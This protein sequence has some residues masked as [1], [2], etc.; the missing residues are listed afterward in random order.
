MDSDDA[1]S[2]Q[3]TL[4]NSICC[5]FRKI[6]RPLKTL[7]TMN[8]SSSLYTT[9]MD[10]IIVQL[11]I[12][13]IHDVDKDIFPTVVRHQFIDDMPSPSILYGVMLE[14]PSTEVIKQLLLQ[15]GLF[16]CCEN[17]IHVWNNDYQKYICQKKHRNTD[18]GRYRDR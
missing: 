13:N 17:D 11:Q 6:F 15:Y 5:S 1:I 10:K 2:E 12:E 3:Q 8:S 14:N 7:T 4:V 9:S 16:L 18:N